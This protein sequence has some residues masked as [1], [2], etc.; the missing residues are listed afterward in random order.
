MARGHA[1]VSAFF[2]RTPHSENRSLRNELKTGNAFFPILTHH[3]HFMAH[4][5]AGTA[6]VDRLE[7]SRGHGGSCR[8]V[9]EAKR[10]WQI[11]SCPKKI[12]VGM[13]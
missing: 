3:G 7:M 11:S 1:S 6:A 10:N 12:A 2:H 9:I 13:E 8:N 4:W 5:H